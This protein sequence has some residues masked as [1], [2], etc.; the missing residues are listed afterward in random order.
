MRKN[1]WLIIGTMLS[2]GVLADDLTNA[3][4]ASAIQAPAAAEAA[5]PAVAAAETNTPPAKPKSTTPKAKKKVA[6]TKRA[7]TQP[8][9]RTVPLVPGPA[10]VVASN[11]NV[12]GQATLKGEVLSRLTKG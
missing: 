9:L 10:T 11:V 1:L 8:V 12:R 6:A 3:P 2:S 7:A 4:A 5:A